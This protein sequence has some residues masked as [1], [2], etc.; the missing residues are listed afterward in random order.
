V[1]EA[2]FGQHEPKTDFYEAPALIASWDSS[3]TRSSWFPE[4]QAR[5]RGA[6]WKRIVGF[7]DIE[8]PTA[9]LL[10]EHEWLGPQGPSRCLP[11]WLSIVPARSSE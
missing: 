2:A 10:D 4:F 9:L 5:T 6:A 1:Y 8:A 7:N 3:K 11:F